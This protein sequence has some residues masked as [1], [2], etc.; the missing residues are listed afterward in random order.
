MTALGTEHILSNRKIS[1]QT[2]KPL[3]ILEEVASHTNSLH[4]MLEPVEIV[5]KKQQIKQ[6]YTN[7]DALWTSYEIIG[8]NLR[9]GFLTLTSH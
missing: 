5:G 3:L 7:S 4:E 9:S 8:N 6:M 2:E 1:I